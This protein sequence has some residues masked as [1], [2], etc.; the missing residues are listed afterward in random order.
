M[1]NLN[2]RPSQIRAPENVVEMQL[3]PSHLGA[4]FV[5]VTLP[6]AALSETSA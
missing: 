2:L 4:H 1:K 5:I 3:P 6:A